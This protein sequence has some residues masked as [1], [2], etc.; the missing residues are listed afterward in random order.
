MKTKSAVMPRQI[1]ITVLDLE[2]TKLDAS[3]VEVGIIRLSE[4]TSTA[5]H[6]TVPAANAPPS[7]HR[8]GSQPPPAAVPSPPSGRPAGTTPAHHAAQTGATPP[9]P[10]S[11]QTSC[12]SAPTAPDHSRTNPLAWWFPSIAAARRSP[13]PPDDVPSASSPRYPP[14]SPA[15]TP[16]H[17]R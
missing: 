13:H 5:P 16:K 14:A 17:R 8:A 2:R 4:L 12:N 1:Q 11:T 7:Q 15:D 10:P 3:S 9:P 6:T